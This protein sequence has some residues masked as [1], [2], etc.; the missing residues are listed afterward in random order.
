MLSWFGGGGQKKSDATKNAIIGLRSQ[1]EMLQKRERH[2]ENLV[3]EQDAAARK[4]VSTNKNAAKSALR[5]KK[6]HEH[7]LE[8]TS[9]QISTL[10]QQIYSIEA[11]NINQET[12]KAMQNAGAAMKRIH[13]GLT[14]DKVDSTMDELREQHALGEEIATAITS[15][16]IG[17]QLDEGELEDELNDLAQE[18]L[19]NKMLKTG[20]VPVSDQV[21]RLPTPA[22]GELAGKAPA[23]IEEEDDEEAELR[24]LQAE[25]AM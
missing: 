17:E 13:G 18:E 3:A 20:T 24:K 8:Q 4:F 1:L 9:A 12:L 19:D 2:L 11:A 14:M 15:A 6:Q 21:H 5:R 22:S 10:E 16:P 25:M 23:H 7:S